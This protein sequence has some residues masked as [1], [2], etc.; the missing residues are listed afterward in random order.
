MIASKLAEPTTRGAH[1][2]CCWQQSAVR[3]DVAVDVE[4]AMLP[5]ISVDVSISNPMT[6]VVMVM[7]VVHSL[8]GIQSTIL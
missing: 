3:I 5:V 2:A 8:L 4:Q 1:P 7:V 6:L